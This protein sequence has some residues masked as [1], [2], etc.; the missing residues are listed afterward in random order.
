M[1][2]GSS[3][4]Q[5]KTLPL[6]ESHQIRGCAV[7]RREELG[8]GGGSVGVK[9]G[10][11]GVRSRGRVQSLL[12][13]YSKTVVTESSPIGWDPTSQPFSKGWL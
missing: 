2:E 1:L 12:D 9:G 8:P 5:G 3:R 4:S 11:G 6:R 7:C 10:G 13:F